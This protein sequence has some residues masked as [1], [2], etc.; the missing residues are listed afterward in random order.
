MS[1]AVLRFPQLSS[2]GP[3]AARIADLDAGK[4]ASA[5]LRATC[6]STLAAPLGLASALAY[7]IRHNADG[8]YLHRRK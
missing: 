1:T 8:R 3:G 4:C 6:V 2:G 5:S 7:A